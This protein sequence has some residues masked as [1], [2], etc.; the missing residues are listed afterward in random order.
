MDARAAVRIYPQDRALT[1]HGSWD[2]QEYRYSGVFTVAGEPAP[3]PFSIRF[4]PLSIPRIESQPWRGDED[5]GSGYWLRYLKQNPDRR[6]VSDGDPATISFPRIFAGAVAAEYR[7][8][9]N[10]Y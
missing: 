9:A 3:S 5:A 6:F 1:L 7:K 8:R 4:D 10:P 2:G